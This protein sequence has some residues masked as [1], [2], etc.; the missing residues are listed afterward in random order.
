VAGGHPACHPGRCA[1]VR[2]GGEAIGF[3]GELHP[4]LQQKYELPAAPVVFEVATAPLLAGQAPRFQGI[5]RMPAVRRD[6]AFTVDEITPAGTILAALRG[7]LP[8]FVRELEVFDQYR[9]KGVEAGKK[10]LALRIVMQDT[11]RTLTD[12]EVEEVVAA[13]RKQ[14]TEQFQAKPRT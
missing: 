12:S 13:V 10:S 5:S 11:D 2:L 1:V 14:L 8:A 3:V 6:T 7:G 9:G 4:R